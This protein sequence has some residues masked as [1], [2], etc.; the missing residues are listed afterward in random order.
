MERNRVPV[1]ECPDCIGDPEAAQEKHDAGGEL[2]LREERT[3][4]LER[5][6]RSSAQ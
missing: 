5:Q 6:R 4:W 2:S 1:R 3:L